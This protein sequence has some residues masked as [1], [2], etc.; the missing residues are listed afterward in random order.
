MANWSAFDLVIAGL[1]VVIG[2]LWL[3]IVAQA[4]Y[5]GSVPTW[6]IRP[7]SKENDSQKGEGDV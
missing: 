1:F 3:Y 7:P 2:L 4:L 6:A 5:W